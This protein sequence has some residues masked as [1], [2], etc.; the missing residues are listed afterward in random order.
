MGTGTW[1]VMFP[2]TRIPTKEA[3]I[4]TLSSLRSAKVTDRGGMAFTVATNGGS[5]DVAL[6]AESY[7]VLETRE[8]V[9]RNGDALDNA[10]EVAKYDARFELLFDHRD[11]AKGDL[12]NPLLAAAERLAK[13]TSGVVYEVDNGVFQ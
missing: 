6:N 8:A 5:F 2:K 11:M 7:V 1:V 3:L 9:D 12:F 10:D 4:T 13:L